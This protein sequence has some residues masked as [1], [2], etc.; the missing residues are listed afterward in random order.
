MDALSRA[1]QEMATIVTETRIHKALASW[2]SRTAGLTIQP[3]DKVRIYR[4]SDKKYVGPYPVIRVDRKQVFV[5]IDDREVQFSIYQV[6]QATTYDEI[7]N[8]E[9]LIYNL[10]NP[11]PQFASTLK[12]SKPKKHLV[13]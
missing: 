6:V 11:M 8:G 4:E 2:V 10:S 1:H 7:V 12:S 5:V 9:R 13:T 3:G